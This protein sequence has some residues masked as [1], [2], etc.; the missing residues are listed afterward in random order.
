MM[1]IGDGVMVI[2]LSL[3][4]II[5][6]TIKQGLNHNPLTEKIETPSTPLPHLQRKTQKE[7]NGRKPECFLILATLTPTQSRLVLR[8]S[9]LFGQ[10]LPQGFPQLKRRG[11]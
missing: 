1:V 11:L 3:L 8:F 9:T 10:N 5:D 4:I 2:F 6:S 7:S